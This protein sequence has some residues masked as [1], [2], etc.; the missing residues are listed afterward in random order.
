VQ[1]T[2]LLRTSNYHTNKAW[3]TNMGE[4][5]EQMMRRI[6]ALDFWSGKA[7]VAP[8]SGGMTNVNF[9]VTDASGKYFVRLGADIPV[10]GVLRF[11]EFAASQAAAACGLSPALLHS[12]PGVMIFQWIAAKTLTADD[13][14]DMDMIARAAPL[15][16]KCHDELASHLRGPVLAFWVFHVIR[17]YVATLRVN[18]SSYQDDLYRYLMIAEEL[19]KAIGDIRM[20]FC[21][22][23]LLPANILDDGK[24]LWLVDWDYAGFNSPLF[25]LANLSTNAGY[26]EAEENLLLELYFGK[27]P[28]RPLK[29]R[30]LAM[31][32]ASALRETLWSMVQELFSDSGTDFAAYTSE[33]RQRFEMAFLRYD[34]Y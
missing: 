10:H 33:N 26:G 6:A 19:E 28:D 12:E 27:K 16:K 20:S 3:A 23:D 31:A 25:D 7:A 8:V 9:A 4:T 14:K 5:R 21:Q 2:S 34:F 30:F 11:N 15:L 32:A 29:Q 24:R 1:L 17:D 18:K 22:N 13:L